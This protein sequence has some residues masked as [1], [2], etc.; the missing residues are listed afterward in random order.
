M[1]G[2]TGKIEKI[3]LDPTE[4]KAIY[5][6]PLIMSTIIFYVPFMSQSDITYSCV[7][8]LNFYFSCVYALKCP[9]AVFE[10]PTKFCLICDP[11]CR[12]LLQLNWLITGVW[13][14]EVVLLN[15]N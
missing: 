12:T 1:G 6:S 15:T 11:S 9:I 13:I 14:S 2:C 5:S 3:I 7:T 8:T 10:Y 4:N